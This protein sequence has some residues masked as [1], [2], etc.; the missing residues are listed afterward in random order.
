[1]NCQNCGQTTTQVNNFCR[2]CGTKITQVQFSNAHNYYPTNNFKS[3]NYEF[4]PPRPYSWKTDEFQISDK[5]APKNLQINRVQPLADFQA[6]QNF[7]IQPFRQPPPM[8]HNYHCPRCSSQ[9]LPRIVRQI[10][11]GG[12]IVFAILLVAFFPLFW[13]GLL[14]KDEIRVCPVCNLKLD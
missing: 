13:V 1:M 12:W 14:I 5:K 7:A 8:T 4:A 3:N 2:F 11:T 6:P 9:L 10:S